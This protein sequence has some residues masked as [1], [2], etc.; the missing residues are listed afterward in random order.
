MTWLCLLTLVAVAAGGS[1][2]LKRRR[3]E[4]VRS[5]VVL[6]EVIP[7][8]FLLPTAVSDDDEQQVTVVELAMKIGSSRNST[9]YSFRKNDRD[10]AIKY[11]AF[12][13]GVDRV[14]GLFPDPIALEAHF[15]AA[16]NAGAPDAAVEFYHSASVEATFDA[17]P[18]LEHLLPSCPDDKP[19]AIKYIIVERAFTVLSRLLAT[20][21]SFSLPTV[22][23]LGLQMTR[24]LRRVHDLGIAH[25]DIHLGNVAVSVRRR[26]ILIDFGLARR[27]QP[28]SI[29]QRA[30]GLLWC[31]GLISPWEILHWNAS[32][33]DD[34]FRMVQL[35]AFLLH[36]GAYAKVIENICS[37]QHTKYDDLTHFYHY[38][39]RANIFDTVVR[40]PTEG[41]LHVS[42]EYSIADPRS[43]VLPSDQVRVTQLLADLL[44]V[45]RAPATPYTKPDYD[46]IEQILIEVRNAQPGEDPSGVDFMINR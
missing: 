11:S 36:G 21:Q 42:H 7:A 41:G 46:R 8:N 12:C 38:K 15:L 26:L 40:V 22:A 32:Y 14:L 33:R 10:Y 16:V 9:V 20:H 1:P 18:K 45:V 19:A 2:L 5:T 43:R 25:G 23:A 30:K 13:T 27:V 4:K 29:T 28:G 35:M 17:L 44:A 31:V 34:I 3:V 39:T 24:L 6:T 37:S